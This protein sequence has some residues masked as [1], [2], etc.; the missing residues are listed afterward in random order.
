M[1]VSE[2]CKCLWLSFWYDF[3]ILVKIFLFSDYVNLS[4]LISSVVVQWHKVL[5]KT[6]TEI[7]NI[8]PTLDIIS[9]YDI[10]KDT[11][12]VQANL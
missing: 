2:I 1:V 11:R 9:K 7:G 6:K 4:V 12:K 10:W 5:C 8:M 3:G